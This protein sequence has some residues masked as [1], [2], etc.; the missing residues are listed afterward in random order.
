MGGPHCVAHNSTRPKLLRTFFPFAGSALPTLSTWS[1]WS[2]A[3]GL[4]ERGRP[5]SHP[6]PRRPPVRSSLPLFFCSFSFPKWICFRST[7]QLCFWIARLLD[8]FDHWWS[9]EL[10]TSNRNFFAYA[11]SAP[12]DL[13][14]FASFLI[15]LWGRIH[16]W[17]N[18]A[19]RCGVVSFLKF[20]FVVFLLLD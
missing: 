14:V 9:F 11:W 3:G 6:Q 13:V 1:R 16:L 17:M 19:A 15:R 7:C 2:A 5:W 4:A 18:W 8:V 20:F 10:Q 12:I